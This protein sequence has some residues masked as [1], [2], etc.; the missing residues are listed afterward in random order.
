MTASDQQPVLTPAEIYERDMVPA[1]FAGWVEPLLDLVAL[2]PRER[3]LD[4]ACGTGAVTRRA[5]EMVGPSGKAV[6]LDMNP[7]MLMVA[8]TKAPAVEWHEGNGMELPFPDA[9]FD[10]LVCQHGLQF[11]P[12]PSVGLRQ[13]RRVLTPGGRL[14]LAVWSTLDGSPGHTALVQALER[15]VGG[16]AAR[17]MS[18]PFGLGDADNLV[19][20]VEAAGFQDVR[21]R[22][23]RRDARFPS[24]EAFTRGVLGGGT[25]ARLGVQVSGAALDAVIADVGQ[26]LASYVQAGGLAYPLE[27]NLVAARA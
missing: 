16:E 2:R 22:R 13:M 11:F 14:G 5:V 6:G 18:L 20:L 1:I 7:N 3:V 24:T 17:I 27:S 21:L 10:A 15:H 4:V 26:A 19:A 9:A 23:E 25:L 12:D 8:R